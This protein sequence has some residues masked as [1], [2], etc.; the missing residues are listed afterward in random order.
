MV[1][2]VLRLMS[3]RKRQVKVRQDDDERVK[4]ELCENTGAQGKSSMTLEQRDNA[5]RSPKMTH[6]TRWF[7]TFQR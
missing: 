4:C 2:V 1:A 3:Q 6:R 7:S 5:R